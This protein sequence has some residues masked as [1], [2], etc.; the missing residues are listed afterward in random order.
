MP[1]YL[2]NYVHKSLNFTKTYTDLPII[3]SQLTELTEVIACDLHM[4]INDKLV[5]Y[6]AYFIYKMIKIPF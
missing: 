2:Q 1:P 4:L 3:N 6:L 5:I